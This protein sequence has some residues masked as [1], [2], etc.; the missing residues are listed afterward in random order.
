MDPWVLSD[1]TKVTLGGNVSGDSVVADVV[2]VT[3]QDA[4][5]GELSSRYGATPHEAVLDVNVPHLLD[6]YLRDRFGVVSGPDVVYPK[7]EP[8]P[9]PPEGAVY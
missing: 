9:A 8:R 5:T 2:R 4:K 7:A 1:G 3:M 6:F